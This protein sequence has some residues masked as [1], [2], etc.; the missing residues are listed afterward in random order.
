MLLI[1]VEIGANYCTFLLFPSRLSVNS[2]SL[3]VPANPHIRSRWIFI[4]IS[5]IP[6]C[7]SWAHQSFSSTFASQISSFYFI[8]LCSFFCFK[9][10]SPE[11]ASP[12]LD[13]QQLNQ[14]RHGS[15]LRSVAAQPASSPK[16]NHQST[17]LYFVIL[18]KNSFTKLL[19]HFHFKVARARWR[20][21]TVATC[22]R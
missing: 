4:E 14:A 16:T 8:V 1:S 2:F 12:A 17:F 18:I 9:Q 15:W 21:R 22:Q 13:A 5:R 10:I 19:L 7:A 6:L 20:L 11:C 3:A